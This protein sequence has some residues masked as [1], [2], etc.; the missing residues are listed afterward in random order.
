MKFCGLLILNL[1][2][3]PCHIF[4]K[5]AGWEFR[6]LNKS[7]NFLRNVKSISIYWQFELLYS[8]CKKSFH[9]SSNFQEIQYSKHS[10]NFFIRHVYVFKFR[11]PRP[12]SF[13][14][15]DLDLW[16]KYVSWYLYQWV[17]LHRVTNWFGLRILDSASILEG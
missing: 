12:R 7:W 5:S 2:T 15:E 9:C 10:T 11:I 6:I 14:N 3:Q 1:N 8:I 16:V 17:F 4:L 13:T